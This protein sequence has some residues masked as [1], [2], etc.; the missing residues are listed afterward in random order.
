MQVVGDLKQ[1]KCVPCEGGVKPLTPDEYGA[2]LRTELT[3]WQD[4]D[5]KM[6]EKEY[7][8]KDFK[9]ALDFVNKVGLLAESEGHHPD[10]NL[11]GWNNVTLTLSTH[12]IGGLSEN[13]FILA[14]KIDQ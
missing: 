11:H 1:K 14:S 12:A 8:F 10:I 3:G 7:K 2:F 9:E 5:A 4:V 6:I 13:D